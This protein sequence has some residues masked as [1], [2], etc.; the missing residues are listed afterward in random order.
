LK[1]CIA[2]GGDLS[3]PSGGTDRVSAIAT[4]LEECGHDVTLVVPEKSADLSGQLAPVDV[5]TIDVNTSNSLVKAFRVASR[6]SQIAEQKGA[7]LQIEHSTLAGVGSLQGQSGYVLDMHDLAYSRFNVVDTVLAPALKWATARLERRAVQRAGHVIVVSEA[8][9]DV[10]CG[11]WGVDTKRVSVVANG[12]FPERVE[13]FL[14]AEPIEGRVAFLGTL[15]PKVDVESFR[16]IAELPEVSE[17]VVIGDGALREEMEGIASS[18][19]HV[20]Y[21]GRLPDADAFSLLAAS[22]VAVNPQTKS[23]LQRSSS[24]VKLY[25][26]AALGLPMVVTPG[27]PIV[28]QLTAAD[29]AMTANT[30]EQFKGK[31]KTLMNDDP[32]RETIS[33]HARD[34]ATN[35]DWNRRVTSVNELYVQ[36]RSKGGCEP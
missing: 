6:A 11:R 22:Q 12:Y 29:A 17:L 27:P 26:Y 35:F 21:T 2:H 3:D 15:H 28:S 1:I 20:R 4:G 23:E 34:T 31:V 19:E 36:L 10:L 13:P 14:E 8:M 33:K 5:R 30:P 18:H 16:C 7:Q 25:N 24:P 9:R 32:L